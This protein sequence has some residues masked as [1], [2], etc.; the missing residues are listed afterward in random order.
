MPDAITIRLA[1]PADA[2]ALCELLGQLGYPAAETELPARLDAIENF[3]GAAAFVAMN[4]YREVVGLVTTHIFPSIHDN[5][6]VAWITTLVVLEDA[7]GAGIG[8]ALVSH[9]EQ[10][11]ARCG[12]RR[13]SVTSGK[14]RV[15]THEWYEKRDY[16]RTGL[17]FTKR[18]SPLP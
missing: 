17:R 6:P 7:R 14:Q 12:A 9:V 13:L 3:P 4:G 15:E 18:L 10:W 1:V 2:P 5:E 8:S 16:E 11:A